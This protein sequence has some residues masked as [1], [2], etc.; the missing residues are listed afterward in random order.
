MNKCVLNKTN[1]KCRVTFL[2]SDVVDL[3]WSWVWV[4]SICMASPKLSSGILHWDE[5][6]YGVYVQLRKQIC[7]INFFLSS[8]RVYHTLYNN[9]CYN[10]TITPES[11]T[12]EAFL[13]RLYCTYVIQLLSVVQM[14]GYFKFICDI[15]TSLS[16]SNKV[17]SG[18]VG[19]ALDS[20]P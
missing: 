8:V 12:V 15:S 14:W 13:P 2:G 19:R 7:L 16:E 9:Q 10:S 4:P 20:W 1:V 18:S 11:E 17:I 6:S 3:L 5:D